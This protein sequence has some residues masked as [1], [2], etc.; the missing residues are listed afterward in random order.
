[1]TIAVPA[2]LMRVA[3]GIGDAMPNALLNRDAWAMLQRGNSGDASAITALLQRAPR[4]AEEFIPPQQ[5][6]LARRD[7]LWLH[8]LPLL[9]LSLAVVWLWTGIVSLGLY[10]ASDSLALLAAAGVPAP[11]QSL[12]LYGAATLDLLLGVLTLCPLRHTRWLWLA[13]ALLIVAYTAIISMRLPDYWLHPYGPI[14]K[15]LP[16]LAVLWLLWA[17]SP[18]PRRAV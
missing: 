9:R 7:A 14:S 2:S 16:M 10:P 3:A 17:L 1:M 5:A 4:P 15:N 18:R 8:A 11:L 13:Q 6:P 12:A